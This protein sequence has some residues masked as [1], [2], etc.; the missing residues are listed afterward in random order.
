MEFSLNWNVSGITS[1]QLRTSCQSF[2]LVW[3]LVW[4]KTLINVSLYNIF[5]VMLLSKYAGTFCIQT[6]LYFLS[7][8]RDIQ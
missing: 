4:M 7:V 8:T 6:C 3:A 2:K 1:D 5:H